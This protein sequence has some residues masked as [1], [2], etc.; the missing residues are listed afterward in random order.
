MMDQNVM[1][2]ATVRLNDGHELRGSA[3]VYVPY[4][5]KGFGTFTVLWG[6]PRRALNGNRKITLTFDSGRTARIVGTEADI[7]RLQFV[8]D[9]EGH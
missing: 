7:M 3:W 5:R 8:L 9:C 2:G 1:G 6:A 4:G